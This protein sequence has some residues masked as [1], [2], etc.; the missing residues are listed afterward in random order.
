MAH[1][2]LSPPLRSSS[3]AVCCGLQS[4]VPL[5]RYFGQRVSKKLTKHT[6]SIGLP[7]PL[8]VLFTQLEAYEEFCGGAEQGVTV[9]IQNSTGG[10]GAAT[11]TADAAA[12]GG[13]GAKA[14]SSKKRS[15]Y[16]WPLIDGWFA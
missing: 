2:A 13:A 12:S 7:G 5:Q 15:A 8:Y 11:A 16:L 3:F 4:T 10:N 1:V 6:A 9:T 14:S